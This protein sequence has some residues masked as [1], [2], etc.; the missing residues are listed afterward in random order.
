M[1][2]NGMYKKIGLFLSAIGPGLFMIGYNIGTGSVTTMASAG[3]RYG[4][5]LFW[6]LL[7]SCIFTYVMIIS[8]GRF[9]LVSGE[10]ALRAIRNHLPF[11]N[12]IAIYSM[13][14]MSIGALAGLAGIIGIVS[15]LISEW[16]KVLFGGN[17]VS[18]LVVA[19]FILIGCYYLLW[20]GKY[21]GFEKLL[22][23]LVMIMGGCFVLSMFMVV[24]A[25][26]EI[27][28]GMLPKIPDEPNSFLI[29]AAMTGTTC[30]AM[31]FVMRSIIVS[32]KGWTIDDLEKEKRDA[33]ISVTL[34][35]I[36]SGV[37]MACAAGTL[38]V[39]GI[40]VERTIDM[41][42]TLEPIAGT[43]A[44]TI[45]VIGIIGA[46]VSSVFPVAI[47]L[48]WFISDYTGTGRNPKSS[49][50]RIIAAL[51]LLVG[52]TVPVLGGRP[53][54]VM[55]GSTAFQATLMPIVTL[56]MFFLINNK[57]LMGK[58]TPGFWLNAGIVATIIFGFA[59]GYMGIVGL[60]KTFIG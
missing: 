16:T 23:S 60:I 48:P 8:F 53:V 55:I 40:P 50:F 49:S 24:P 22:S 56:A 4:M 47:V 52:L 27:L 46:G 44:M 54:W 13:I 17:G 5:G 59:T 3:S 2:Q 57:K 58:H 12:V 30:G 36:L 42:K 26:K 38:Y 31:L 35:L 33:L 21:S 1:N 34:M 10:T 9:T 29:I 51:S 32:E 28:V 45:F 37:I 25:P 20:I 41:V 6:T 11:G 15:E 7:F 18:M 19:L 14:G 43:F 39:M